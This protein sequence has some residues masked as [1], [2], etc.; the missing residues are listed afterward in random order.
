MS[1]RLG[2]GAVATGFYDPTTDWIAPTKMT[3]LKSERSPA[4]KTLLPTPGRNHDPIPIYMRRNQSIVKLLGIAVVSVL[5]YMIPGLTTDRNNFNYRIPPSWS[6]ENDQHYS[7]RAFMTDISLWI[8]LT[9]LQPHEQCA[10]I[11][12]RLGGGAREMARMIT[13][14]EMMNGGILNGVAVDAV[15]YLIGTLHAKFS[16]LEEERRLTAMTEMLAFAR[17]PGENIS[18]VLARYEVVR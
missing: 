5:L 15:T 11:I 13:P 12:M 9:D 1:F 4:G 17:E 8:M 10:A 2:S 3:L 18:A 14:Q 16:V 7:F 6:P